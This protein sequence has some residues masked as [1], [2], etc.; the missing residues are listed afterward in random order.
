MVKKNDKELRAICPKTWLSGSLNR[1]INKA[2]RVTEG[3]RLAFYKFHVSSR[4]LLVMIHADQQH[5][6]QLAANILL[7]LA[8]LLAVVLDI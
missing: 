3:G 6:C 8:K 7:H 5:E 4:H 1:L 2:K